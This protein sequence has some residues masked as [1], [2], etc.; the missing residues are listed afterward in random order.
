MTPIIIPQMETK[1]YLNKYPKGLIGKSRPAK[2]FETSFWLPKWNLKAFKITT[3]NILLMV[4]KH[5]QKKSPPKGL[6][7]KSKQVE[8]F[9]I[10]IWLKKGM[11]MYTFVK[12][13]YFHY[14]LLQTNYFPYIIPHLKPQKFLVRKSTTAEYFETNIC[15]RKTEQLKQKT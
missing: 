3:I 15:L 9:E 6:A 5:I 7:G 14:L 11:V 1:C 4:P 13:F 8:H 2:H 12:V 10:R